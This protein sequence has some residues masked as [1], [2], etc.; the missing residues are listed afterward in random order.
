MWME[1]PPAQRPGVNRAEE[2]IATGAKTVATGC[3]FCKIMIGD[4]VALVG[5][6]KAPPV[7]D[8]AEIMLATLKQRDST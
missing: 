4:S 6:E 1:E 3:P 8:I 5:G 7:L 2:L